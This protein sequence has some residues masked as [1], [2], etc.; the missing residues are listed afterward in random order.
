M[1]M[2][3]K[4]HTSP[5]KGRNLCIIQPKK[6]PKKRRS[7]QKF[8]LA[9]AWRAKFSKNLII[10]FHLQHGM[11]QHVTLFLI[12]MDYHATETSQSKT[13]R[14]GWVRTKR[15]T[16]IFK[17]LSNNSDQLKQLFERFERDL[18]FLIPA[19]KLHENHDHTKSW[20]NQMTK[21]DKLKRDI[22]FLNKLKH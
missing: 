2:T 1:F 4:V 14:F 6:R 5:R 10:Y 21:F 12:N 19:K 11:R 20:T 15:N 13:K 3:T 17:G 22:N 8:N 18:L 16:R 7:L 9:P